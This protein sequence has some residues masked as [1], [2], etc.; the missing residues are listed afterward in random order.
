[1]SRIASVMVGVGVLSAIAVGGAQAQ[2]TMTFKPDPKSSLAWWQINPH[3]DHL[4][5][6]TCPQEPSWRPGEGRGG[7]W[8]IAQAFRP[9]KHG[10]AGVSDTTIIPLYPRRRV[11]SVC[12]EAMTG[13]VTLSDTVSFKGL[14]GW[15]SVKAA[16]LN[17][18]ESMRDEYTNKNVT[19]VT[20][21]P[22]I[23][24]TVD[25]L[26]DV[27]RSR[28][29]VH[30]YA[31]GSF[32]FRGVTQPMKASVRAWREP[33]GTRVLAKFHF[34]P[35]D[36]IKVYG[37]SSFVLGMGVGSRIWYDVYGGVDMVLVPSTAVNNTQ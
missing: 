31:L 11:R 8:S 21:Y 18:G 37:V 25:S 16:A 14:S 5:A 22:E 3:M 1:M 34:K 35:I 23:K 24:F 29:T 27:K 33:I 32:T 2:Q 15:I 4:W 20:D 19:Q 30:A 9:P 13:E 6:S 17:Q 12:T 26:I 36:L 10:S 28:D 7:G